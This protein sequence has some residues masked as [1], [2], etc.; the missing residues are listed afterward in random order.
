MNRTSQHSNL[1]E[2]LMLQIN[3]RLFELGL[4]TRELYEE[5]KIRIII[6]KK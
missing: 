1:D 5:A 2:E 6:R 4:L 3:Q